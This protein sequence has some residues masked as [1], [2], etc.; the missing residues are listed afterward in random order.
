[1]DDLVEAW[2]KRPA[3]HLH[4]Q[5]A[6]FG[7]NLAHVVEGKRARSIGL[8]RTLDLVWFVELV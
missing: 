4:L 6:E 8:N 1:L 5:R 2:D 3:V 7:S